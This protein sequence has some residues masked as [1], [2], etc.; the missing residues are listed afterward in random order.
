M[1]EP[2][3]DDSMIQNLLQRIRERSSQGEYV[4]RGE[5]E[6]Y[7]KIASTLYRK[8]KDEI[9][10]KE[11]DIQIAQE[12][13]LEQVKAYTDFTDETDMLTELQHYGGKTNLIDFTTDYLIALFFACDGS[14]NENG[15]IILL[16]KNSNQGKITS[17]KKNQNNRVISQKSIFFQSPKGYL[18]EKDSAVEVIS[19]PSEMKQPFLEYLR[20]Y[21]GITT[22][23]IYSDI[24]GYIQNQEKH[25]TAYT[26]FYIGLTF[27]EKGKYEEAIEHY[28]EATRINPQDATAYNNRGVAKGELGRPEEAIADCNEAIR[29]NPQYA[30]PYNNRGTAKLALG[31]HHDAIADCDRAIHINPQYADAY[32]NRGTAKVALGRQEEAI[33]DHNE[34]IRINP[35]HAAAYTNR[36]TAKDALGR[37]HE[38]IVDY[39]QAIR[40]NPQYAVVYYNRGNAKV[41]LGRHEEAI[42]DYDQAIRLNPQFA[43]TYYNRGAA[44][45]ALRRY[46]EAIADYDEA[47]RIT[48]QYAT[49]YYSKGIAN[50][51]L[52]R[53]E[54]AIADFNEAI[55]INP[56]D[57]AAYYNRGITQREI[58]ECEKA[59]TDFQR[60][61]E[62]ATEQEGNQALAQDAR[63]SL[64]QLPPTGGG[65][66]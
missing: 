32:Y 33:T 1:S 52:G 7:D 23:A 27:Q 54:E 53:H 44:K 29:I 50:G 22:H 16:N 9:Q 4:Y 15:R 40:L 37:H 42:A 43:E 38:A 47:I 10:A 2:E 11:F 34:A 21:H 64:D 61:L 39:D 51:M 60:A 31:W 19:I 56:Q 45:S 48:P 14:A 59:R 20:K 46:E 41:A 30:L 55:R 17:P 63:R 65:E 18:D 36:G 5:P 13:M 35:Q 58:G 57:A 26:E 62:L 3:T 49:A 6:Q 25:Q 12:E 8:Y 66:Y 28:N 24:F